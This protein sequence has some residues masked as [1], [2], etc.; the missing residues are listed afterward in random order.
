MLETIS[1]D[2]YKPGT[3]HLTLFIEKN[4]KNFLNN[5]HV[6]STTVVFF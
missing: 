4:A 2:Y 5:S 3:L 6:N 1:V